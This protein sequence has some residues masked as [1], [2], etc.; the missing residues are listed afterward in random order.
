MIDTIIDIL[1]LNWKEFAINNDVS[2]YCPL[3]HTL[4]EQAIKQ[5]KVLKYKVAL[6]GVIDENKKCMI[7]WNK[8]VPNIYEDIEIIEEMFETGCITD[9]RFTKCNDK[10]LAELSKM[11]KFRDDI[12]SNLIEFTNFDFDN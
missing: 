6:T 3:I 8:F 7:A 12:I 9:S 10:Q 2:Q 11:F 1:I 4:Y 5:K